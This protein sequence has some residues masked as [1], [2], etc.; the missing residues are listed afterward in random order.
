MRF[1]SEGE[2]EQ[3]EI[4]L[5]ADRA[6][7]TV[8]GGFQRLIPSVSARSA[9]RPASFKPQDAIGTGNGRT[10]VGRPGLTC[11]TRGHPAFSEDRRLLGR[12]TEGEARRA[13]VATAGARDFT[14][15]IGRCALELLFGAVKI[16][17]C[18]IELHAEFRDRGAQVV[19]AQGR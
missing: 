14:R 15:L 16:L 13:F 17:L 1:G 19:P 11:Q 2:P 9:R 18:R 5:A 8:K 7:N 4:Q 10:Q 3:P 6:A 12:L